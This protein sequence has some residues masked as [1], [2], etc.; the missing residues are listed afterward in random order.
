[1]VLSIICVYTDYY[2]KDGPVF[3]LEHKGKK[4]AW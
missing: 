4:P 1:M 2:I 3:L